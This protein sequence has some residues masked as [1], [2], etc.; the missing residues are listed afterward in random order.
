[1]KDNEHFCGKLHR[2]KREAEFSAIFA[3]GVIRISGFEIGPNGELR[4]PED[5]IRQHPPQNK[6]SGYNR[7]FAIAVLVMIAIVFIYPRIVDFIK[8]VAFNIA[9]SGDYCQVVNNNVFYLDNHS[10]NR[11]D[12]E[13]K[14]ETVLDGL[15]CFRIVDDRLYYY[16]NGNLYRVGLD[17]SQSEQ[18]NTERVEVFDALAVYGDWIWYRQ[19]QDLCRMSVSGGAAEVFCQNA[20]PGSFLFF[21]DWI[22]F[23]SGTFLQQA[24]YKMNINSRELETIVGDTLA[25]NDMVFADGWIYFLGSGFSDSL[26]LYRVGVDGSG[27]EEIGVECADFQVFGD[28]IY[29]TTDTS[30]NHLYKMRVDGSENQETSATEW[31][32]T[33]FEYD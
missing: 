33:W 2:G 20:E 21:D 23:S 16:S 12:Q 4:F 14:K 31:V 10:L 18:L 30:F 22:V 9:L 5:V 32:N 25:Q 28:W 7:V 13:G 15:E 27:K 8:N 3:I 24:I 17:G 19:G 29:Y 26:P 11:I 6:S 1:M